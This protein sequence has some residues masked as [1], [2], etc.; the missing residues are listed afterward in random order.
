QRAED[1]RAAHNDAHRAGALGKKPPLTRTF[2]SLDEANPIPAATMVPIT[3]P[4]PGTMVPAAP[5]RSAPAIVRF[6]SAQALVCSHRSAGA[7]LVL[8]GLVSVFMLLPLVFWKS[9]LDVSP[10]AASARETEHVVRPSV[11]REPSRRFYSF[12]GWR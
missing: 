5:P 2:F 1:R 11:I 3:V 6:L 8:A 9:S 12:S 7:G 10:S 4:S